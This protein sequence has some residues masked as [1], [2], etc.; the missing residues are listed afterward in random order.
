ML[1]RNLSPATRA[2]NGVRLRVLRITRS[3]ISAGHNNIDDPRA[4]DVLHIP[5]ILFE[6]SIPK[7]ALKVTRL[8]FPL[9]LSYAITAN[10]GSS[11]TR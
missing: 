5:R 4:E 10:K 7:S 8:Q 1:M 9:Q 11:N 2:L 3:F 6:I